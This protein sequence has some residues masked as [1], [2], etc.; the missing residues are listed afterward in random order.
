[1]IRRPPR[2]TLFPYTTLFRSPPRLA[3]PSVADPRLRQRNRGRGATTRPQRDHVGAALAARHQAQQALYLRAAVEAL[4]LDPLAVA[5][6]HAAAHVGVERRGLDAQQARGLP[7]GQ[8]L[9]ALDG[10][11]PPRS[12]A[13]DANRLPG[14][15]PAM[16]TRVNINQV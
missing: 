15:G 12:L 6:Q 16:S 13:F 4:A 8:V 11:H 7:H 14:A 10:D 2:S 1:M 9:L 5:P 3:R